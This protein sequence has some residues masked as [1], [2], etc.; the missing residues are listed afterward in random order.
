MRR[1]HFDR[2]ERPLVAGRRRLRFGAAL[3]ALFFAAPVAAQDVEVSVGRDTT[4]AVVTDSV[5]GASVS[6]GDDEAALDLELSDGLTVQQSVGE[7]SLSL[8]RMAE[9]VPE[10]E[11][12]AAIS[13]LT[14]VLGDDPRLGRY[15]LGDRMGASLGVA[16]EQ[17]AGMGLAP[18]K[19]AGIVDQ[20]VFDDFGIA[21][22]EFPRRECVQNGRVDQHEAGLVKGADQVLAGP[23]VDGGLAADRAVDLCQ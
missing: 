11:Q 16:V 13:G 14:L 17:V 18:G 5:I 3:V 9:G 22:S 8:K 2:V 7:A 1:T 12:C 6:V 10:I 4:I 19:E 21:R 23:R 15:A 20:S